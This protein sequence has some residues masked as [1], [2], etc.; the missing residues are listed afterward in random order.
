MTDPTPAQVE[1][2]VDEMATF[3]VDIETAARKQYEQGLFDKLVRPRVES[4]RQAAQH[5][6]LW[7]RLL[8]KLPFTI[9]IRRKTP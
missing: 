6:S 7:Q 9:T 8:D 5:K 3:I 1:R 2:A 4:L